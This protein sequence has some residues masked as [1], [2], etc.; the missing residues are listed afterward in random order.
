[1]KD[2]VM[3]G[4]ERTL[5]LDGGQSNQRARLP[6][7]SART[8]IPNSGSLRLKSFDIRS[9]A[10]SSAGRKSSISSDYATS[11]DPNL[12]PDSSKG[13]FSRKRNGNSLDLQNLRKRQDSLD[14]EGL[15]DSLTQGLS[16]GANPAS[17]TSRKNLA[18]TQWWSKIKTSKA[19]C[20]DGYY[21]TV[22]VNGRDQQIKRRSAFKIFNSHSPRSSLDPPSMFEARSISMETVKVKPYPA[23]MPSLSAI[24]TTLETP[25]VDGGEKK[26]PSDSFNGGPS[27]SHLALLPFV[28][29]SSSTPLISLPG[30]FESTH[31]DFKNAG[32]NTGSSMLSLNTEDSIFAIASTTSGSVSCWTAVS[33]NSFSVRVIEPDASQRTIYSSRRGSILPNST[34]P[35]DLF[36]LIPHQDSCE[37]KRRYQGAKESS[38][39][40]FFTFKKLI[41]QGLRRFSPFRQQRDG[42]SDLGMTGKY[43]LSALLRTSMLESKEAVE[44]GEFSLHLSK[45]SDEDWEALSI[46]LRERVKSLAQSR[47]VDDDDRLHSSEFISIAIGQRRG[48]SSRQSLQNMFEP[49]SL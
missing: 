47:W 16:N 26:Q 33:P 18:L 21:S 8:M 4:H 34:K 30:D 24:A 40:D 32:C 36:G 13:T 28:F 14:F 5:R 49:F 27:S 38:K 7:S 44:S 37:A 23:Q 22:A 45:L 1:M 2:S 25:G 31:D 6:F 48:L 15:P 42:T 39:D 29:E 41:P 9:E 3:L 43:S 19:A 12:A 46:L 10:F 35:L 17:S 11:M 20:E